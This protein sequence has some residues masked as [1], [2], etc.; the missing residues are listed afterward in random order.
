M[1]SQHTR[2][3]TVVLFAVLIVGILLHDTLSEQISTGREP[4]ATITVM[5][6]DPPEI[7]AGAPITEPG[8]END[9][10][11][12]TVIRVVDGDT[13]KVTVD[14]AEQTIRLLGIDAP[15]RNATSDEPAECGT[16]EAKA[17]LEELL[18]V[19]AV[20]AVTF[21]SRSDRVDVYGRW[22]AYVEV[23]GTDASAQ[24]IRSG[25]ASAWW[26]SGEP[27]PERGSVYQEMTHDA[28]AESAG[29]WALCDAIGRF[30]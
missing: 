11:T 19:D 1:H 9:A 12:A 21:D 22:L 28:K 2:N 23:G 4:T 14:G 10:I 20:V 17:A 5:T 25:W 13:I 26:P 6:L 3:I 18:P 16:D 27:T 30:R 24:Q 29:G 8:L 15:E 7:P